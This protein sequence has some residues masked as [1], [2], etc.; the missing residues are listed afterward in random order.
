MQRC[1]SL[2]RAIAAACFLL[3]SCGGGGGAEAPAPPPAVPTADVTFLFLGNSHTV[4]NDVPGSV[5]ALVRAA[6]PGRSVGGVTAPGSL[7]LDEHVQDSATLQLLRERRWSFV[8]LQA[9]RSSASWTVDYPITGAVTLV[10]MAR[11]AGAV[12]ILFPEWPRRGVVESQLL[13]N[14]YVSIA[15][16]AP[17]C[18]APV[19]QAFDLAAARHPALVLHASDGNH[20]AP[21][22]AFLAALILAATATGSSP[23]SLPPLAGI[24]VSDEDQARLRGIAT[25]IVA[26]YPPRAW[27]P[28]DPLP[29]G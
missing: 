27:C 9:Q 17:A 26:T 22:G 5:A 7:F 25:E 23:A 16:E 10:R 24:G 2:R 29:A 13:Y 3:A 8:V 12:P 15:R 21:A 28:A 11:D 20:S 4:V 19:P 1:P 6:L 14:L 18:V